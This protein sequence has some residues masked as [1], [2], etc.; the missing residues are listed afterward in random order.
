MDEK[1]NEKLKVVKWAL[2]GSAIVHIL[3]VLKAGFNV[4]QAFQVGGMEASLM[5]ADFFAPIAWGLIYPIAF[6]IAAM[7]SIQGLKE[8]NPYY[9]IVAMFLGLFSVPTYAAPLGLIVLLVLADKRIRGPFIQ[10]LDLQY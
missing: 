2:V 3:T 6:L 10:K 1:Y 4:Y 7:K 9:W 5:N 8:E